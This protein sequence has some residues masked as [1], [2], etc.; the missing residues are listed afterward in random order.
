M[1][2]KCSTLPVT[3]AAP[4]SMACAVWMLLEELDDRIGVE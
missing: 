2:W 1:S 3:I 4:Y